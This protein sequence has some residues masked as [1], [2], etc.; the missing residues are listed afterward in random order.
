[1]RK[2]ALLLAALLFA[3]L[4]GIAVVPK[5]FPPVSAQDGFKPHSLLTASVADV[6]K[7]AL[8]YTQSRFRVL[9]AP[10]ILL[11]RSVTK[12]ELPELGL[13]EIG[14]GGKEPPLALVVLEGKFEVQ[15][16]GMTEPEQVKYLFYVINLYVGGPTLVEGSRDGTDYED[17]LEYAK[18]FTPLASDQLIDPSAKDFD[19]GPIQTAVPAVPTPGPSAP[20][21]SE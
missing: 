12:E 15:V 18:T 19:P 17:L 10:Q 1:M 7:A 3:I 20:E 21:K 6:Q 13:S 14:F 9:E 8:D 2:F 16:R 5:L 11:T 4:V